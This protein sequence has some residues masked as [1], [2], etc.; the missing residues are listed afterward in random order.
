MH[1]RS[2]DLSKLLA[3]KEELDASLTNY[4]KDESILEVGTLTHVK[5]AFAL[6]RATVTENASEYIRAKLPDGRT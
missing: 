1:G 3:C 6:H 5:K 2:R 4:L